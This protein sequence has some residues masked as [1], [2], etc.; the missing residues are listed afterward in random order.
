MSGTTPE[1]P[2]QEMLNQPSTSETTTE[3]T[4]QETLQSRTSVETTDNSSKTVD[5]ILD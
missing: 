5:I 3:Q 1:Q 2:S 4:S